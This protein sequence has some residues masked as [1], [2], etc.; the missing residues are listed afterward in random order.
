MINAPGIDVSQWD[1]AALQYGP[2]SAARSFIMIKVSEGTAEDPLFRAQWAAA[3]GRTRRVPYHF[4]RSYVNSKL[5]V[6]AFLKL[7]GNDPGE[8]PA[9]LDLEASD[10]SDQVMALVH[11]WVDEYQRLTGLWPI[12]YSSR[13]FLHAN[14]ADYQTMWDRFYGRYHNAWLTKC[15]LML[16]EWPFDDVKQLPGYTQLGNELRAVLIQEV[17][18]GKRELAW[19][20]VPKPWDQ[21][22][23]WQWTSRFPPEQIPG[24]FLGAN[25]KL[26]VDAIWH[27]LSQQ[28]FDAAYP[29]PGGTIPPEQPPAPVQ[30]ITVHV[31][32]DK[33]DLMWVKAMIKDA[34]QD[35]TRISTLETEPFP[36]PEPEPEPEPQPGNLYD[37]KIR[38]LEYLEVPP[39]PR[40]GSFAQL[41]GRGQDNWLLLE[42]PEIAFI[43][44]WVHNAELWNWA[45]SQAGDIYTSRDDNLMT[46]R[47]PIVLMSS[48]LGQPRQ[49]VKLASFKPTDPYRQFIGIPHQAD[50]DYSEYTPDK[51]PEFFLWCPTIYP[52]NH[53]GWDSHNGML[54]LMPVFQPN[55]GFKQSAAAIKYG[56][57][58]DADI[59]KG[60]HAP[61]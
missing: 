22:E 25:H 29:L 33:A 57:M 26:A 56:G 2:Y 16:A 3:K 18:D 50:G 20:K 4:W 10:G 6:S 40:V 27:R 17:I 42:K 36:G 41:G 47:W 8:F 23:W 19:P 21:V 54:F 7:L 51:Y 53:V 32:A 39:P 35:M 46:V 34:V 55:T 13:G 24:Y 12:L 5:A 37:I 1:V 61:G 30:S 52:D 38:G 45:A 9:M 60:P 48:C 44:R 14:G 43:K 11:V 15:P 58:V 49:F 28:A 31:R 59:F